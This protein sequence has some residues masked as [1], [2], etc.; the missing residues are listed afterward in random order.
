MGEVF[1]WTYR[2]RPEVVGSIFSHPSG[3]G[4]RVMCHEL[5]SLSLAVLVVDREATEQWVPQVPG[6]EMIALKEAPMPAGTP[7]K[8][9]GRCAVWPASSVDGA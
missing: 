4:R 3:D 7:R 1:V 8:D 6:V 2:S 5:H 9:W